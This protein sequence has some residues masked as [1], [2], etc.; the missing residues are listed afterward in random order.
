MEELLKRASEA[1][2]RE[3]EVEKLKDGKYIVLF[4]S[5]T[6]SP[7]PKADTPEEALENFIEWAQTRPKRELPEVE[8]D[9]RSD[10]DS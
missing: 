9:D 8:V 3:V 2:G 1:I 10:E 6:E 4:M 7:P 5:L